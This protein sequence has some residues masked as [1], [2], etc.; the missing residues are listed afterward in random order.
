MRNHQLRRLYAKKTGTCR[1]ILSTY[2]TTGCASVNTHAEARRLSVVVKGA[3]GISCQL[4]Y[5]VLL[6]GIH[7][8]SD[9]VILELFVFQI[10]CHTTFIICLLLSSVFLGQKSTCSS[11]NSLSCIR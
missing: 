10:K 1:V 9:C 4:S 5:H 11:T 7:I 3:F 8:E 6:G 2:Y